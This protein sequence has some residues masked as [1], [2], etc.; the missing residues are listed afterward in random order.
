MLN[1]GNFVD[2][3]ALHPRRLCARVHFRA[4]LNVERG[5]L[6]AVAVRLK[7]GFTYASVLLPELHIFGVRVQKLVSFA[8]KL[9]I[10]TTIEEALRYVVVG[11]DRHG[12]AAR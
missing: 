7:L 12:Y 6:R 11:Y 4:M 8:A 3:V 5:R 9:W 2:V 1:G 10:T